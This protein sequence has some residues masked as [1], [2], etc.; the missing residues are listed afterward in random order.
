[1]KLRRRIVG[2]VILGA[3]LIV[4]AGFAAFAIKDLLAYQNPQA[5]LPICRIQYNGSQ[6][7]EKN[8]AMGAY[9]WRFLTRTRDW[10]AP[11]AAEKIEAAPVNANAP[12]EISF[13]FEPDSLLVSRSK[14]GGEYTE[15]L[16]DLHTPVEAGEYT[17]RI[18]GDWGSRRTI[19]YYFKVRVI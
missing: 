19:D 8:W 18:T 15:V 17:Y 5:A 12:L 2:K 10:E 7:P 9:T 16:G 11:G 1:M 13:S 6:L 14:D 4:L 3:A